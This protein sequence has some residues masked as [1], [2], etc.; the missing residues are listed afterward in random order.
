MHLV[1]QILGN[2][3]RSIFNKKIA[4]T[5]MIFDSVIDKK[6][7]VRNRSRLYHVNIGKY[8]YVGRNT[9]IQHTVIGSFCSISEEC[10]IGMPSHPSTFVST[11]PVFLEGNNYL[12]ENFASFKYNDCP[13]THIGNDVWIGTRALIKAGISV[14][15]GAIIAAGAVVTKDVPPYAI[16]GGVPARIIR[17]RFDQEEIEKLEDLRW[18]DWQNEKIIKYSQ[19]FND[20]TSIYDGEKL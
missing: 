16:V 2:K 9:L 12:Y 17:F 4:F 14:G 13:I 18:W 7:A 20:V 19:C 1:L 15:N 6:A 10:N 3:I 5:A 11:S 8:T